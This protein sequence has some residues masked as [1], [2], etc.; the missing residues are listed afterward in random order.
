MGEHQGRPALALGK[1]EIDALLLV[2]TVRTSNALTAPWDLRSDRR[3]PVGPGLYR[4]RV[5]GRDASD[6]PVP[7]QTFHI[8]VVRRTD[9]SE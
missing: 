4:V 3:L 5:L 7:P 8:G 1:I 2:R 6:R 9:E